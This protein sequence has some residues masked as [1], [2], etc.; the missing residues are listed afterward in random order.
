VVL[1]ASVED[2]KIEFRLVEVDEGFARGV[3]PLPER[4]KPANRVKQK[5]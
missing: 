2:R 3:K 5:H 1:K 4:G